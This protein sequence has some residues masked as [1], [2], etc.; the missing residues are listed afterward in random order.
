MCSSKVCVYK[1]KCKLSS[2]IALNKR[3][4]KGSRFFIYIAISASF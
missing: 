4:F 1:N 3:Y 2:C